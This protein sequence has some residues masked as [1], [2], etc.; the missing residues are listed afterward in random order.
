M[1]SMLRARIRHLAGVVSRGHWV[2]LK[3][4]WRRAPAPEYI[5]L[6][7]GPR[8]VPGYFNIDIDPS[9]QPDF[10]C[11]LSTQGLPFATGSVGAIACISTINYFSYARARQIV[12]E[13]HRVLRPGGIARFGVQDLALLARH[14]LEHNEAFFGEKLAS[15]KD[16][17][18]GETTAD[19]FVNFFYGFATCGGPARYMYDF[20][21]LAGH[22]RAAGFT[23]IE[24]RQYRDSR[25]AHI[26]AIDNREEQMFF[27]EAIK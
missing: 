19:K 17:F 12:A 2:A 24:R 13:C 20:D 23:T 4:R 11:N 15:G 14:Y 6:G 3:Y 8:R 10:V 27:L 25:L 21:S 1:L 18:P 9:H 5:N 7:S 16:R 26:E 22:F